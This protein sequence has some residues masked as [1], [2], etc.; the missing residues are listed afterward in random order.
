MFTMN[1]ILDKELD[2]HEWLLTILFMIICGIKN[3]FND[4]AM[5]VKYYRKN[6]CMLVQLDISIVYRTFHRI[7]SLFKLI[8][9]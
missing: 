4:Y 6:K 1:V 7:T 2:N 8:F 9:P 3:P 5:A